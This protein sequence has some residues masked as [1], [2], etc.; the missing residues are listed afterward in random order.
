MT[1][2]S[3]FSSLVAR[4]YATRLLQFAC[5]VAVAFLLARLLGPEGRGVYSLLLLLPS[6]LFAIGQLGLPS[7][8]TFFAGAGRSLG[9]LL[10]AAIGLGTVLA[11]VLL[12]ASL[13]ALPAL[14]PVLFEAAPLQL[15]QVA[16]LALPIQLAASF[17]GSI[18]WGRQLV[19][20]YSRVLAVQSVG[21]LLAVGGLVG[22]AGVG[23]P[24]AL[25]SYMLVT[26]GGALAVVI[27]ALRQRSSEQ[28]AER[29]IGTSR[30]AVG[31]GT[32]LGYGL[33]LY[34]AG[35]TTFLSYRAD[36]FLLSA[37]LG[38]AAAIGL[39]AVAVSF[40]EISFQVPDSVATV[41]YPRVAGSERAEADRMAPSM[42][43]FT[44]LASAIAAVALI[45]LVWLAIRIVLPAF[46]GSL[47]PFLILLP[48]A[49]ALGLSKVLSGYISGLG[50]PGPVS[51]IAASALG[52]N[53]ILNLVLIPPLGIVGA[54]LASMTSY[55]AHAALTVGLASGLSGAGYREFILPG[56]VELRLLIDRLTALWNRRR[57]RAD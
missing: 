56:R 43:R 17:F 39:Y 54:A 11:G 46:D 13:L 25:A 50:R 38:D 9:S 22:V 18:L 10:A 35:L 14:Q 20:P 34:P 41:F 45:P 57:A 29:A 15:L 27:L 33:R 53:L 16:A 7:A 23:V 48:G 26:G 31:A 12:V 55:A 30:E 42:A 32:L 2:T 24:G 47:L 21:W 4:V 40:A 8:L 6:T 28:V 49:V 37:L 3:S 1:G 51:V 36:L 5:T 44:L 19:R 52:V